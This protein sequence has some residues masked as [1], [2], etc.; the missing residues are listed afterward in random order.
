MP[1]DHRLSPESADATFAL[2]PESWLITCP[3]ASVV[4]TWVIPPTTVVLARAPRAVCVY[5][6]ADGPA[7]LSNRCLAS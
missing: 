6:A 4:V 5:V 2:V 7:E 1:F 3:N